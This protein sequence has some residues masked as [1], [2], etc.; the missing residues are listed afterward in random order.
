MIAEDRPSPV[1]PL[2]DSVHVMEIAEAIVRSAQ[3]GS[4]VELPAGAG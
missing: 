3:R 1:M 2:S 4:V